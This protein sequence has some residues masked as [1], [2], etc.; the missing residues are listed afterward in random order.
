M[1]PYPPLVYP[2]GKK[3]PGKRPTAAGIHVTSGL[4]GNVALDFMTNAGAFFVAPEACRVFRHSGRDPELGVRVGSVY[5]WSI[6]LITPSGL[7]YFATHLSTRYALV[8]DRLRAG[9]RVGLIAGWPN[10]PG[11]TH[12]HLGVTHPKGEV[13]ARARILEVAGAPKV[14]ANIGRDERPL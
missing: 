5:A 1:T 3:A 2:L 14:V 11:R 9:D 10:D 7:L 6:Y 12:L 13:K 4:D 8:G